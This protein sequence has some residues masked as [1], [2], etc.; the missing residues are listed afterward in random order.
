MS[1]TQEMAI[2][3]QAAAAEEAVDLELEAVRTE[4]DY[5]VYTPRSV[6]GSTLDTG[7]EHFLVFDG[8]DGSLMAVW[9]QSSFEGAGDHRIMW[10]T[11]RDAGTHWSEARFLVGA[12]NPAEIARQASWGFPLVSQRGRIYV[13]YNQHTGVTDYHPQITGVMGAIYSDDN[14]VSWSEPQ[15]VPMPRSRR[16]DHPDRAVPPNWVIWQKPE[17]AAD[18]RYLTGV[19][20]WVSPAV[21][22][23]V[24][25]ELSSWYTQEAVVELFGFDNVDDNPEP[26][27]LHI[28]NFNAEDKALRIPYWSTPEV[29]ICQEL[30]IVTL[31]DGRL[32]G[33]MRSM[34][35]YIWYSLSP[36]GRDW[37]PPRPL[38]RGDHG[39]IIKA[40]LCCTPVYRLH[41]GRYLLIHQDN[42]GGIGS[43]G[44]Q[45]L[46][47][48]SS[49]RPA[50]FALGEFDPE[51]DQ[52]VRFGESHAFMD[53][54]GH[55]IGPLNRLDCGVY[56]SMTYTA[57]CDVLWHPDR[58]F[59]LV[60]KK[61]TPELLR[62]YSFNAALR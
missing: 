20:R 6:D 61:I 17:R 9:T 57:G 53:N 19:T 38:R 16:Y 44:V 58:K 14:G 4:P 36:D 41:D 13:L 22:N 21:S 33:T 45:E 37:L 12:R 2:R 56:S 11:S 55:G 39:A 18:G 43:L 47:P 46:N 40:P 32:F 35:G 3:N 15:I 8:P 26:R 49:R 54:G 30:S 48:A 1:K 24:P 5:R 10:S 52:P 27:D 62:S 31:P 42:N 51:A 25:P 50:C 60:G 34:T 7:N 28:T 23:K 59:F 29:S